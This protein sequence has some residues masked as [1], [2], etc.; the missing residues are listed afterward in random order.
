MWIA[1]S[2]NCRRWEEVGTILFIKYRDPHQHCET[3]KQKL[4]REV[5]KVLLQVRR[6]DLVGQ[7]VGLVEEEDDGRAGE[8]G[9]VDGRVEQS[10]ALKHAVLEIDREREE[11]ER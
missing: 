10:Q 5:R 8:P 11:R 9:R 6:L 3:R 1:F 4:T 7:D 2:D